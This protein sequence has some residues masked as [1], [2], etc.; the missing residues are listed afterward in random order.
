MG[1]IGRG[2]VRG[3]GDYVTTAIDGGVGGNPENSI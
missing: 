2:R 1:V 3:A